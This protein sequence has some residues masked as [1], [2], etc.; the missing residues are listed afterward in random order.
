MKSISV[1]P[2]CT[3]SPL[4]QPVLLDPLAVDERAVGTVQIGD[5]EGV[6]QAADFGVMAGDFGVV[7]L[8]GVRGVAADADHGPLE[9]EAGALIDSANYKQRRHVVSS[10]NK[11]LE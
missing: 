3:W 5:G 2:I 1:L 9:F 6:V 11:V 10:R 8:D 4:L 7:Q